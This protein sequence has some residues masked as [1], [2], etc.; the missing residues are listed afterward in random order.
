L[1]NPENARSKIIYN[2]SHLEKEEWNSWMKAVKGQIMPGNDADTLLDILHAARTKLDTHGQAED[3]Q[4]RHFPNRSVKYVSN[5]LS[6]FSTGR[7]IGSFCNKLK[8]KSIKK[9]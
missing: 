7:K 6:L 4:I 3:L 8:L 2:L 9:N 5:M 1:K